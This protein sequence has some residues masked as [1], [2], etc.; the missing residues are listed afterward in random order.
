M[1]DIS[2]L[3]QSSQTWSQCNSQYKNDQVDT[4]VITK[5]ETTKSPKVK[6]FYE[7]IDK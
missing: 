6:Q 4:L 7:M 2:M 5:T 1:N 3:D